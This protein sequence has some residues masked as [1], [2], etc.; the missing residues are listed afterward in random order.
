MTQDVPQYSKVEV[1]TTGTDATTSSVTAK[2]NLAAVSPILR[3]DSGASVDMGSAQEEYKTYK[4]RWLGLV[5]LTLL[6]T[7]VSWAW[8]TFAPV[9]SDAAKFYHVDESMINW[10]STIFVFANFAMTFVTIKLLDWGLRPTITTGSVLILVGNWVRYAGSYSSTSNTVTVV[11]VG[12]ALL[13]MAQSL[14][15]S[16]PTRFSETWFASSGRV[17]ATAV[18]SLANP[19]GAALGQVVIPF[20]VNKSGDV[21]AMV[22]YVSIISSV[23]ALPGFFIPGAPPTPPGQSSTTTRPSIRQSLRALTTSLECFLII[24][25]FWVFTGLF[26]ATTTLINQIVKPYDFSDSEAGIGGGLLIVLGLVASG[27]A[28]PVVDRTKK[29]LLVIKCGVVLGALCYLALIWVPRARDVGGLY[30]LLGVLGIASLAIVPVVL[31]LLTEFSYPA[32]P[33]ITSTI[34]WAGGQL[35]GGCL[36]LLGD[37]MKAGPDAHI[38][39]NM[40]KYVIFQAVLASVLIPLPLSLGMF[41]RGDKVLLKRTQLD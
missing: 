25:P 35:L 21:A 7:M 34:A 13:G 4:M 32:G 8:L 23:V 12:Q 17:T 1:G 41:G 37:A 38:P 14:V 20:W 28:A 6:N 22:L 36:I 40:T 30:A 27:I 18:M 29:F 9:A 5:V 3:Q 2:N 39:R 33:E 11:A 16:A 19:M 26:V 31:E 24:I 15:L 10:L